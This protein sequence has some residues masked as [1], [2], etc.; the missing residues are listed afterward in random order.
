[1][2]LG[3]KAAFLTM[4]AI[5]A[6]AMLISSFSSMHQLPEDHKSNTERIRLNYINDHLSQVESNLGNMLVISGRQALEDTVNWSLDNDENYANYEEVLYECLNNNTIKGNLE[7]EDNAN[8]SASLEEW[9]EY[10]WDA[11]FINSTTTFEG[12][13]VYHEHPWYLTFNASVRTSIED[14]YASWDYKKNIERKVPIAELE[15]PTYQIDIASNREED[16]FDATFNARFEYPFWFTEADFDPYRWL[17]GT[18]STLHRDIVLE[19]EYNQPDVVYFR[20]NKSPSFK[21]RMEGGLDRESE[22][23]IL[24][25]VPPELASERGPNEDIYYW[26]DQCDDSYMYYEY[27][28]FSDV[29]EAT[30]DLLGINESQPGLNGS[31]IRQDL[32]EFTNM[33]D[34]DIPSNYAYEWEC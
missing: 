11:F 34:E 24:S 10:V 13:E 28:F 31:I 19:S 26:R 23:G 9:D 27:D 17:E 21:D 6:S 14:E 7:C 2:V 8:F 33:T 1:M 16:Q 30:E 4:T 32:A 29:S 15:D 18:P 22:Y 5:I 12:L 25:I 3:K 20:Y